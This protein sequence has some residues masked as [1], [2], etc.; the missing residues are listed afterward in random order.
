MEVALAS[1]TPFP[2]ITSITSVPIAQSMT[3]SLPLTSYIVVRLQFSAFW[4]DE[5]EAGSA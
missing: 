1:L 4:L 2:H 3:I 5:G